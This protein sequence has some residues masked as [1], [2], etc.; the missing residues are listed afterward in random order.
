MNVRIAGD[1]DVPFL[2]VMLTYATTMSPGGVVSVPDAMADPYLRTYVEGW[3]RPDDLGVVA[4]DARAGGEPGEP[5]G[6]AWL[7]AGLIVAEPGVPE[8]ATAVVPAH[9]GRGVGAAMMGELARR[10]TGRFP[11]ILLS[12]REANPA[13]RLYERLGFRREREVRNRVGGVSFVMRLDLS[14]ETS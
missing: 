10:A 6:A 13:V 7:R 8:L 14:A 4:I 1:E 11:A 9:R 2:W 12:V 5:I 3:G